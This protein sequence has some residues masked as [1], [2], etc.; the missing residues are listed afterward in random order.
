MNYSHWS[1]GLRHSFSGIFGWDYVS[2]GL[3]KKCTRLVINEWICWINWSRRAR[4]CAQT[5]GCI[6]TRVTQI[7]L[8]ERSLTMPLMR[9]WQALQ[10][11]WMC[12]FM[13][14]VRYQSKMMV[15]GCRSINTLSMGFLGWADTYQATQWCKIQP[16]QLCVFR[17]ASRGWCFSGKCTES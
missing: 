6:L 8:P 10:V 11:K 14:M 5:T 7:T 12:K 2:I 4:A 1:R 15:V 17:R 16:W 3:E 9:C 13:K